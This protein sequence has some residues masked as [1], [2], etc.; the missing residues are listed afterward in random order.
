MD[1]IENRKSQ[2]ENEDWF[3]VDVCVAAGGAE[4]IEYA[5]NTLDALGTE[6]NNLGRAMPETLVVTGYFDGEP[7]SENVREAVSDALRVYGFPE[8]EVLRTDIRRVVNEDWLAEWKKHWKPT[9]STRFVV[10]PPWSEVDSPGK[11]VIRIDPSMAF[12]T[13]THET[14][15][16]CLAAIEEHYRPGE[17]F[18]DLGTGTGLLAIAAAKLSPDGTQIEA[19]DTDE[20]SVAIAVANA[21]LNSTP[22]IRFYVGSIADETP[23][24]DFVCANVTLD[25]I[26]PLLPLLLAKTRRLLVLSGILVVQEREIARRLTEFGIDRPKIE[27][28][29]EWIGITINTE[30]RTK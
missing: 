7:D 1:E 8:S 12:G 14:T 23:V 4:S 17:S 21:E 13:G 22:G 19:C 2:V 15:R 18:F 11:I 6:I 28:M 24:F 25:V 30:P 10:A 20:E 9:E 26:S 3:A 16:L 5:L 29:G 27:T